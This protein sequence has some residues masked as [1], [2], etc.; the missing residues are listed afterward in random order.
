LRQ[1]GELE[2]YG[3]NEADIAYLAGPNSP[4]FECGNS[5]F[6]GDEMRLRDAAFHLENWTKVE[7]KDTPPYGLFADENLQRVILSVFR[8][9]TNYDSYEECYS[10]EAECRGLGEDGIE[11]LIGPRGSISEKEFWAWVQRTDG[12]PKY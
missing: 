8:F 12:G 6:L 9:L 11:P 1:L 3:L 5:I 10:N 2:K 7:E 4:Y